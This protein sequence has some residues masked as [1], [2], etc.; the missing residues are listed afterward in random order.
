[1]SHFFNL[2]SSGSGSSSTPSDLGVG[3]KTIA[4]TGVAVPLVAVS[5]PCSK[6]YMSTIKTNTAE[7]YWGN[8]DVDSTNGDYVFPATKLPPIE[9]DDV[10]KIYING[11][12]GDGVK[13][14]FS[15]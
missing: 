4:V 3:F 14:T 9:I 8:E 1:M 10:S 11:T 5:T 2:L 13:F 12:A 7:L 6:V 15:V